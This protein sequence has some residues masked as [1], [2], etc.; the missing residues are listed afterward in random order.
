MYPRGL[1]ELLAIFDGE[2]L[3]CNVGIPDLA[4]MEAPS[5]GVERDQKRCKLCGIEVEIS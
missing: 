4:P 1:A 5:D 3:R 2:R